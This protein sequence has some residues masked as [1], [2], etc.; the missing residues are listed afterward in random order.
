M[1]ELLP[2]LLFQDNSNLI[3]HAIPDK[4]DLSRNTAISVTEATFASKQL[5]NKKATVLD[6]SRLR[7]PILPYF[8]Q[9]FMK[10]RE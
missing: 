4:T 2:K 1:G 7:F 5:K 10:L 3:K 6:Q 9:L 8:S